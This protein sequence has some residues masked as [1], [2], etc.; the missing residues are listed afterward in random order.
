MYFKSN[1]RVDKVKI[2]NLTT[3]VESLKVK[4]DLVQSLEKDLLLAKEKINEL[5]QENQTLKDKLQESSLKDTP[6]ETQEETPV[7]SSK[8]G[9]KKKGETEDAL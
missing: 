6:V 8:A 3:E 4:A 5:E 2:D 9:R 1:A 7:K